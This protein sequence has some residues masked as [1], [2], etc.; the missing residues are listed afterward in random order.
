MFRKILP[1]VREQISN[2][3]SC[4]I[5][6]KTQDI[7][8]FPVQVC[9]RAKPQCDHFS[10]WSPSIAFLVHVFR[11][12]CYIH[13]KN[14]WEDKHEVTKNSRMLWESPVNK[15][16]ASVNR[17]LSLTAKRLNNQAAAARTP[18]MPGCQSRLYYHY[19]KHVWGTCNTS[20]SW[21]FGKALLKTR[22]RNEEDMKEKI[23]N[24]KKTKLFCLHNLPKSFSKAATIRIK[25]AVEP[26]G[27]LRK[28]STL[29]DWSLWL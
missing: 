10:I 7:Q 3:S 28:S 4:F 1:K 11:T 17:T 26:L 27:F 14:F 21:R 23:S 22:D 24:R 13:T 8:F 6:L 20:S 29:Q 25:S 16:I 9:K 15:Q 12:M 2:S 18:V 5:Q 19:Y